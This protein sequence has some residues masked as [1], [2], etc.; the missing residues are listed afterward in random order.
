MHIIK[1]SGDSV[2]N[3]KASVKL[4]SDWGMYLIFGNMLVMIIYLRFFTST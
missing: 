1:V 3:V 4:K 2:T